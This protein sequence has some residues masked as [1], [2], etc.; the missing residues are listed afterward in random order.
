MYIEIYLEFYYVF[1]KYVYISLP[2]ITSV[3]RMIDSNFSWCLKKKKKNR[4]RENSRRKQ[5]VP[6]GTSRQ[7]VEILTNSLGFHLWNLNRVVKELLRHVCLTCGK[8]PKAY[9]I[10]ECG[11]K[12][13][14][15]LK[16]IG[17]EMR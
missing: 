16:T 7:Q 4:T 13:I 5:C 17:V 11:T 8:L 12:M 2:K 6:V 1:Y 14:R 9:V 15:C 3:L 10:I